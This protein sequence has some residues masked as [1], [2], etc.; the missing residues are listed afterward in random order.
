MIFIL[1]PPP[2]LSLSTKC[3]LKVNFYFIKCFPGTWWNPASS[4]APHYIWLFEW[5]RL[6]GWGD[7]A[8]NS[9]IFTSQQIRW[10]LWL[11][12]TWQVTLWQASALLLSGFSTF[13]CIFSFFIFFYTLFFLQASEEPTLGCFGCQ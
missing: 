13:T 11:W 2:Q 8:I 9:H 6:H 7:L 10:S 1:M 5:L 4:S 12:A 3:K